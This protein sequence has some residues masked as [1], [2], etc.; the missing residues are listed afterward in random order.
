MTTKNVMFC[1]SCYTWEPVVNGGHII[2]LPPFEGEPA[3]LDF[4]EGPFT[5]SEPP[6]EEDF[7]DAEIVEPDMDELEHMNNDAHLFWEAI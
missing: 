5:Y 7:W 2:F 6:E 4:C 3:E 1:L